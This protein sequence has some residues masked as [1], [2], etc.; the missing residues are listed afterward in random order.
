LA[1]RRIFTGHLADERLQLRRDRRPSRTRF[2][3]PE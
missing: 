3:V 1:P 2:P